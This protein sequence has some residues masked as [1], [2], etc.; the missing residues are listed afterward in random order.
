MQGALKT[1]S[2]W[3]GEVYRWPGGFWLGSPWQHGAYQPEWTQAEYIKT[4][5]IKAL[6]ERGHVVRV[7]T[8]Q[9]PQFL[10]RAKLTHSPVA[11]QLLISDYQTVIDTARDAKEIETLSAAV[12]AEAERIDYTDD[13]Q[14]HALHTRAETAIIRIEG[15]QPGQ[16]M[17]AS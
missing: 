9:D 8:E 2:K 3:G 13:R 12:E 11:L 7:E 6:I 4:K 5:M 16:E 1:I 14:L 17:G 15:D 10:V